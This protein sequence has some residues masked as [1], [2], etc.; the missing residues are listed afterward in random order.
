METVGYPDS[1]SP[2]LSHVMSDLCKQTV[3]HYGIT[4]ARYLALTH[5][6]THT[7]LAHLFLISRIWQR[8]KK[9]CYISAKIQQEQNF[10]IEY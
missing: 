7:R 3:L 10:N 8:A 2:Q 9:V 5:T 6:H 1:I 4:S